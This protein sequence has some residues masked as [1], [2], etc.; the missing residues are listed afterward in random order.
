[1]GNYFFLCGQLKFNILK[2]QVAQDKY[3][4]TNTTACEK[5]IL[6][7]LEQ[8]WSLKVVGTLKNL[9]DL[10]FLIT[11]EMEITLRPIKILRKMTWKDM[12]RAPGLYGLRVNTQGKFRL[13]KKY[14]QI[15]WTLFD[16][17]GRS[18]TL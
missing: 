1:M 16:L 10:Q 5:N 18:K 11:E 6:F 17:K 13:P 9:T 4:K 15:H 7:F 14:L 3:L 12:P 2:K 8:F